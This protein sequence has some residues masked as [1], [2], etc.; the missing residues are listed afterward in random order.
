MARR[1][2]NNPTNENRFIDLKTGKPS[3]DEG[4]PTIC[5]RI[6]FFRELREIEQVKLASML[7]ISKNTVWHWDKGR[8]RPDLSLIPK[9]CEILNVTPYALLGMSEPASEFTPKEIALVRKY[10]M[11]SA[12][13]R[14]VVDKLADS[15]MVV[16]RASATPDLTELILFDK[17]LAAGVGDPTEFEEEGTPIYLYSSPVVNIADYVFTV[18]GESMEPTYHNGDKVLVQRVTSVSDLGY[19]EIGAFIFG[20]EMYIKVFE[21]DGLHSLNKEFAPMCFADEDSVYLIGRV[22]GKVER[23]PTKSEIEQYTMMNG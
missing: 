22:I 10:R 12:G 3:E 15:L 19:G 2:T 18:N 7:G 20:N 23:E 17:P 14:H 16:E 4:I 11:L 9:L 8:A 6:K 5:A 13:H 1:V 21:K